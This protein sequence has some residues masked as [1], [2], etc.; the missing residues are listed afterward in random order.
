MGRGVHDFHQ[1]EEKLSKREI[2]AATLRLQRRDLTTL[3]RR[4]GVERS[5][6]ALTCMHNAG[7]T[8]FAGLQVAEVP[9]RSSPRCGYPSSMIRHS[10][11][12]VC[13]GALMPDILL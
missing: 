4:C 7:I 12:A 6:F 5:R 9:G 2:T 11:E 3:M 13:I 1:V 8:H 10:L